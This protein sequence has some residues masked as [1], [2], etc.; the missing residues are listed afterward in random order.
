MTTDETTSSGVEIRRLTEDSFGAK[1]R[2]SFFKYRD[3]GL[4]AATGG[5]L[6]AT[7][8]KCVD[9]LETTGFHYHTCDVQFAF[10]L[11]GW[12][13]IEFE[14]GRVERIEAGT[15]IVIPGGTIHNEIAMSHDFQVLEI[16]S[17]AEMGT[18][19]VEIER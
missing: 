3:L 15:S 10:V 16:T 13:D 8:Y 9:E 14:G 1:G 2:R 5:S 4:G 7:Q 19:P 6:N 17:P 12:V 11:Q 18:V